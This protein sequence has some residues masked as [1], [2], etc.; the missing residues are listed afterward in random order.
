LAPQLS[1]ARGMSGGA[2][3]RAGGSS[4][5][6]AGSGSARTVFSGRMVSSQPRVLVPIPGSGAFMAAHNSLDPRRSIQPFRTVAARTTGRSP[7]FPISPDGH[8]VDFRH[9]PRIIINKLRVPVFVV[10]F[11][12]YS[13]YYPY[14]D[15]FYFGAYGCPPPYTP[16]AP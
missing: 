16:F 6:S 9:H 1:F 7:F 12:S 15:S 10:S 4:F 14:C 13:G 8:P 5:S 3:G 11:Q 2:A